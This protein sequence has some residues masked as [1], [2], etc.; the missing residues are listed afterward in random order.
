[1][2]KQVAG[3]QA[4]RGIPGL[5]RDSAEQQSP[6]ISTDTHTSALQLSEQELGEAGTRVTSEAHLASLPALG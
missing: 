5:W 6:G 3:F 2:S 1:M 4:L